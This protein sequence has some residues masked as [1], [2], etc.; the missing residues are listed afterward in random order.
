M[1][2]RNKEVEMKGKVVIGRILACLVLT[3]VAC[4]ETARAEGQSPHSAIPVGVPIVTVIECGEGYTSLELYDAKITLLEIVRGEK[5]WK[6]IKEAS[7]SNGPPDV[8]FEYILARIK[9][10]FFKRGFPGDK[11]YELRGSQ[12]VAFSINGK[13]Y[14]TPPVV[15]PKPELSGRLRS[16]DSLEGWIT[17]KVAIDDNKPLM[18]FTADPTGAVQHGGNIWFQ[19][20]P[21][22]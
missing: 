21:T 12:F 7:V 8:S 1:E 4:V 2:V 14:K 6:R 3:L 11:N 22:P 20:Y 18:T 5:A 13:E 10:E 15:Q 17:F 19:L 16:G 9:F